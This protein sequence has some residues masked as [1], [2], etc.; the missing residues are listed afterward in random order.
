VLY[1]L[2]KSVNCHTGRVAVE[3]LTPERRRQ[4]TRDTLLDAAEEVFVRRGVPG[5]SMEEIAAEAGFSRGAIYAHFGSKDDLLL[6]VMDRFIRRQLEQYLQ[7]ARPDDPVGTAI[8][9]AELVRKTVSRDLVPLELELRMNA[10]RHPELRQ[11]LVEADRRVSDEQARLIERMLG[12]P[13]RLR[14]PAQDLADLG[15]AA[16]NGL[17]QWAAVD[18]ERRDRYERLIQTMFLLLTEA[19]TRP[20]E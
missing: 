13:E 12:G 11:R 9:A 20:V 1:L 4:R 8:D 5:A 2:V 18:E 3:K 19:V 17:L 7:L 6:A 10:L 16:V 15:R 14:I